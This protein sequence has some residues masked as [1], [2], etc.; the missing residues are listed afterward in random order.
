MSACA[1]GNNY[2]LCIA[3]GAT[4]QKVITWKSDGTLVNLSAFTARMQIR[5]TS[6]AST[7]LIELTT[8]NGRIALGGAA[9]TITLTISATDTAAL[10]AGRGVYD[11]E[12]VAA[13][14]TVTRLLQGVVTISRNIT[15]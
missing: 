2:D 15:R 4:F 5:A 12:L 10:T 1:C 11:L 6:E 8:E 13:N 14:G 9:G 3:Q 7:A